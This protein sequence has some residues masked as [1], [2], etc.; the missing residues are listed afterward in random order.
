MATALALFDERVDRDL[1]L[2]R[3]EVARTR[4]VTPL[5]FEHQLIDLAVGDRRHIVL[6]EGDDDRIL[7]AADILLRRKVADLTIL[8]EPREIQQRAGAA[9]R[10]PLGR[11]ACSARPTRSCAGGSRRRTT[12]A[13]ST[14]ASTSSGP[15]TSS[16]TCPTSAR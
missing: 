10:R 3:L 6:P 16:S 11:S 5:M 4:A 13:A 1:L 14:R 12:N 2:D 9:R 7:Q 15:A 8:G